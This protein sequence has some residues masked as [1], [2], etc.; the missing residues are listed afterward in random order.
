MLSDAAEGAR[1][2]KTIKLRLNWN[3]MILFSYLK[4]V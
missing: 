1:Y 4:F 2:L 3:L